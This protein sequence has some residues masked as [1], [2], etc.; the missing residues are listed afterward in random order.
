MRVIFS[1]PEKT[2]ATFRFLDS[3]H[4]AIINAWAA[5]GIPA[6]SVIGYNSK[7]WSFGAVGRATSKGFVLRSVVIGVENGLESAL[8]ALEADSLRKHSINGD[9]INLSSWIKSY[10]IFPIIGQS[11]KTYAL[12]ATMISPLA[13]SVRGKKGRWHQ[14]YSEVGSQLQEA[15]NYRLSRLTGRITKLILEPDSLYLRANP[16]HSHLVHTRAVRDGRDAFVIGMKFPMIIRGSV[17]DLQSAWNLGIGEKNRY[18]FGCIR[19]VQF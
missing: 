15:V 12:P 9:I 1:A 7:N 11:K 2:F 10:E 19:Y 8:S 5:A 14:K 17:E 6:D 16:R 4:G 3:L 18:G 13:L